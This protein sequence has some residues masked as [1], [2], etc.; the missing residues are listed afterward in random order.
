VEPFELIQGS[1]T[2]QMR[3]RSAPAASYRASLSA[4]LPADR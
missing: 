2:G 3:T 4:H 1:P